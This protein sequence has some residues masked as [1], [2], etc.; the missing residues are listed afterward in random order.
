[1]AFNNIMQLATAFKT[2]FVQ[3]DHWQAIPSGQREYYHF[4]K[5]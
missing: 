1:M 5:I 2:K 3:L 4:R